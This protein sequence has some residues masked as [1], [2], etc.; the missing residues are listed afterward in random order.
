[1]SGS[2][3]ALAGR[4]AATVEARLAR[5]VATQGA[6][7]EAAGAAA[8]A[9]L[10]AGARIWVTQTSHTLHLELTGRAGGLV[11]VHALEE[12]AAIG[13]GDTVLIGTTAGL[14]PDP[15]EAALRA[16]QVGATS[17]A[18]IQLAH[19][20]DPG[21]RVRHP[22]GRRLH[23]LADIVIDLGGRRGD[24]EVDLPGTGIAILPSSGVTGVFAAW[25]VLTAATERLLAD[26][27]R[28]LVYQSVLEEGAREANADRR[29][30]YARSGLGVE[31]AGG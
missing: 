26:G 30:R 6:A 9:S 31:A 1:M 8:A 23:E 19:E 18:L 14:L 29:A 4:W 24:G 25:L 7:I 28:P 13:P 21:L 27:L 11:A 3:S 16:R 15:I 5:I 2:L 20:Q 17:V 10:A 12:I 22:A